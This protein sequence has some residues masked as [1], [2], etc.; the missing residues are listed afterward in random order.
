MTTPHAG[1]D[2]IADLWSAKISR[3]SQSTTY[4]ALVALFRDVLDPWFR[5]SL[6]VDS[7]SPDMRSK[8]EMLPLPK[9]LPMLPA[10]VDVLEQKL[11]D[12]HKFSWRMVREALP[13]CNLF[14]SWGE[15]LIRPLS[16]P[17]MLHAPFA[18]ATQ[19]LYMSATLG[20]GGELE[21]I[22]GVRKIERLPVP[23]GWERHSAGRRLFILPNRSMMDTDVSTLRAKVIGQAGRGLVLTP[24]QNVA[25]TVGEALKTAGL[26]VLTSSDIEH[27]TDAFTQT[28][29]AALVLTNRYDGIDLPGDAC[30]L[31]IMEGLPG[32]VN[33]QEQFLLTRLGASSLLRD[34]LRTRFTQGAG[35]CSRGPKDYAAILVVGARFFEFCAKSE[36]RAGMHPELQAELEFGLDNSENLSFVA[37]RDLLEAFY[38]QKEDWQEA[39]DDIRQRR[40][41]KMRLPDPAAA[42]LAT[43]VSAE[44]DYVYAMWKRD[45]ATALQRAT[46]VSD[47]LAGTEFE[48]YRAFWYYMGGV[49]AWLLSEQSG[50]A[51]QKGR[52]KELFERAS[53]ASKSIPWFA[54]LAVLAT[55][56]P[57]ADEIA[58][59]CLGEAV[60]GQLSDLG[61]VGPRFEAQMNAFEKG[62]ASSDATPF[63]TSLSELGRFL[64]WNAY[65]PNGSAKP[66]SVWVMS[67]RRAIAVEAKSNEKPSNSVSVK[68]VRQALTHATTVKN[69][70]VVAS[71]GQITVIV[72]SSRT[73]VDVDAAALAGDLRY[74]HI[75]RLRELGNRVV[76]VLRS[77][78]AELGS[79][80]DVSVAVAAIQAKY[81]AIGF[82]PRDVDNYL[83]SVPLKSLPK[84]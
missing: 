1:E 23:R 33:L 45:Y 54:E 27:S 47:G 79:G 32:G 35:R 69:D 57:G 19:R 73:S 84:K 21:R 34:R 61:F 82:M 58:E 39:D 25:I 63:E 44:V 51:S 52:A 78:R 2:Y 43:V 36:N 77:L 49:A 83:T 40:E 80:T 6:L 29:N 5:R 72:V 31:L 37:V 46:V 7:P 65:K 68:T 55:M 16:P 10:L 42:K 66:D 22:T 17:T 20:S 11:D 76:A 4:H 13:A 75:D 59:G 8:V 60:Y 70:G 3:H 67:D 64:G 50:D 38:A 56:A 41:S 62:M 24:R 30:R 74:L 15:I 12:G 53:K 9:I 18:D 28:T 26:S 14:I 81:R 71:N 48:G